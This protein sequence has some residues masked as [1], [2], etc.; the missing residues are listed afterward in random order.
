[1]EDTESAVGDCPGEMK[2]TEKFQ[3]KVKVTVLIMLSSFQ[4]SENLVPI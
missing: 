2:F 3:W 4:T 1:M